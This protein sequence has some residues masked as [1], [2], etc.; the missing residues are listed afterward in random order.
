MYVGSEYTVPAYIREAREWGVSKRIPA[1]SIPEGIVPNVSRLFLWHTEVIPMIR[2]AG[3]TM[4]DL[5][6]KL[7][8]MGW[9][10]AD[11]VLLYDLDEPWSP[12]EQLLPDSYVPPDILVL[13][14]V[15]Q[16]QEPAIRREIEKEFG[17]EWQG[18][19]FCWTYLS[20]PQLVV[21]NGQEVTDG[22]IDQFGPDIDY[23]TVRYQGSEGEEESDED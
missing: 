14:N 15:I 7:V 19:V 5:A 12:A 1:N 22:V 2:A 13:T 8:G 4:A 3:K 23:V 10:G 17:I 21:P 6:E 18:A 9:L 20:K 16:E 11:Q